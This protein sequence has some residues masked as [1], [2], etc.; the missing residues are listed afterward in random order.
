M[1]NKKKT[2]KAFVTDFLADIYVFVIFILLMLIF[3]LLFSLDE[4]NTK[5]KVIEEY[6]NLD[7]NIILQNYLRT[8][9]EN[10]KDKISDL[11]ILAESD[12]E[13][14]LELRKKTLE[15][16]NKY[17]VLS[18][19]DDYSITIGYH[20]LEISMGLDKNTFS[21]INF[22]EPEEASK[23][24]IPSMGRE[25]EISIYNYK[26]DITLGELSKQISPGEK[27]TTSDDVTYAYFGAEKFYPTLGGGWLYDG[28]PC[29]VGIKDGEA[30]CKNGYIPSEEDID[31]FV[32]GEGFIESGQRPPNYDQNCYKR[33]KDGNKISKSFYEEFGLSEEQTEECKKADTSTFSQNVI[34]T[35][36]GDCIID[37]TGVRWTNWGY[38]TSNN[39]LWSK[40]LICGDKILKEN[41]YL[42]CKKNPNSHPADYSDEE[43]LKF[44]DQQELLKLY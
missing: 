32:N 17:N 31:C 40:E 37:P 11:I 14:R 25:I 1:V 35:K 22:L 38:D 29:E 4:N 18:Y 39:I 30:V 33:D 23:I 8:P 24:Q 13:K 44:I 21:F 36:I 26:R 7:A 42:T 12:E 34:S 27:I 3:S 19:E 9:L 28:W 20:D 2:K 16:L 10:T 6:D 15:I 5:L 41:I 43:S